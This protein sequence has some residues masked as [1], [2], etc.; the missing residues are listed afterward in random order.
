LGDIHDGDMWID[1]LPRFRDEEQARTLAY[2]GNTAPF[3]PLRAGM[4]AL[5]HK[6]QHQREQEYQAFVTCWDQL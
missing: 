4:L 6:R 3:E 2:C 1:T 5:H